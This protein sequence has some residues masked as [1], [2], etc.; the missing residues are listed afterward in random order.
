MT[1]LLETK[2]FDPLYAKVLP[3]G[4]NV[5]EYPSKNILDTKMLSFQFLEICKS[6]DR[7]AQNDM[8]LPTKP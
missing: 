3:V 4:Y 8:K 1:K 7:S 5:I 2:K 6:F